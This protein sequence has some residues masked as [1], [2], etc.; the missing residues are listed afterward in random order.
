MPLTLFILKYFQI[1]KLREHLNR[2]T[3]RNWLFHFDL[4]NERALSVKAR[5]VISYR[6]FLSVLTHFTSLI[7]FFQYSL[8]LL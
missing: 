6:K 8:I 2:I 5:K 4:I 7:F 1:V 3:Q